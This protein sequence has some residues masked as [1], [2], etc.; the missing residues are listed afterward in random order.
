MAS[1]RNSVFYKQADQAEELHSGYLHK[2]PQLGHLKT[3]GSWKRRFFILFR[4]NEDSYQLKYFKNRETQDKSM[5]GIDLSQVSLMFLCTES[6]PLWSWIHKNFR[7]PASCVLV[8]KVPKRDYY[9]IGE[10]SEEVDEW[11]TVLFKAQMNRPQKLLS[12]EIRNRLCWF[13]EDSSKWQ[14]LTHGADESLILKEQEVFV[15]QED[16]ATHLILAENAGRP[17]VSDWTRQGQT[18]C[19][20]HKGDLILAINDLHTESVEE[21]HMY[22]RKLLKNQVKLTIQRL[23]G[24]LPLHSDPC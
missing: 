3:Y 24:S 14:S 19:L 7:C 23:P 10:N 8:L 9:L 1:K 17:C 16:L 5:G 11:F 18:T 12:P 6:H 20:F 21:V 15:C 2:S 22:L 4:L 13:L